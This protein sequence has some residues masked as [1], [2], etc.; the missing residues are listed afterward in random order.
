MVLTGVLENFEEAELWKVIRC[1][2]IWFHWAEE[3][4]WARVSTTKLAEWN[5][6]S[7]SGHFDLELWHSWHFLIVLSA[8][9]LSRSS[10][11]PIFRWSWHYTTLWQWHFRHQ[12]M[13]HKKGE[14]LN[15]T[16]DTQLRNYNAKTQSIILYPA[17]EMCP[18]LFV[19]FIGSNI[20]SLFS[21]IRG[22]FTLYFRVQ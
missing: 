15:F 5:C 11:P 4:H 20:R 8:R 18:N 22:E 17:V 3:C 9:R 16:K 14:I 13:N 7:I 12:Y 21:G 6:Q 2:R 19:G 1:R 10:P